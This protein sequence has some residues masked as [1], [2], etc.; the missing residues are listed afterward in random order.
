MGNDCFLSPKRD[1]QRLS[2]G[3]IAGMGSLERAAGFR[4]MSQS[5]SR[6][7]Q[8]PG[9]GGREQVGETGLK[10][11]RVSFSRASHKFL[12]LLMC[13]EKGSLCVLQS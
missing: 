5:Q 12:Q 10:G 3:V 11:N 6:E 7:Q 1:G 13:V 9:E 8:T 2:Q 4:Q